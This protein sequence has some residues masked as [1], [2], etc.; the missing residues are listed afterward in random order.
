[1]SINSAPSQPLL[2][3]FHIHQSPPSLK[4]FLFTLKKGLYNLARHQVRLEVVRRNRTLVLNRCDG[5]FVESFV[6]YRYLLANAENG[7]TRV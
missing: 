3:L 6:K 5:T 2:P 1:M 7:I 4:L